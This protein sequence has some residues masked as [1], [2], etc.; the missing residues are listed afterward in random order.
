MRHVSFADEA[1]AHVD[2]L[3][4]YFTQRTKEQPPNPEAIDNLLEAI[5]SAKALLLSGQGVRRNY[6]S[7]YEKMARKGEQWLK[8]HRYWFGYIIRADEAVIFALI[9]ESANMPRRR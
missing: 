7:I 8:V 9:D 1:N 2:A 5:E 3:I 6:P 4:A